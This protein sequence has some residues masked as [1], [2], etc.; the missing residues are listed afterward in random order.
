MKQ[1]SLTIDLKFR[2]RTRLLR[3]IL[4]VSLLCIIARMLYFEGFQ[5]KAYL[6]DAE[7]T[8]TFTEQLPAIRGTIYDRNGNKLAYTSIAYIVRA[9]LTMM[10]DARKHPGNMPYAGDP[11]AYAEKLSPLLNVPVDELY[12]KL[13]TP[14]QVGVDLSQTPVNDTVKAKIDALNLPGIFYGQAQTRVY[15]N[16]TLAAHVLG[17]VDTSGNG[18]Y[19]IEQE[20]DKQLSGTPGTDTYLKDAHGNPLPFTKQQLVAAKNGNDVYLTL[21]ETIQTYVEQ[22]LDEVVKQYNPDNASVIVADPKSG[23]ILAMGNRPTYDPNHYGDESAQTALNN[24]RAVNASFEPGSTFKLVPLTGALQENKINLDDTFKSGYI[25]VSGQRINDWWTPGW[26]QITFR[27]AVNVSSNVGFVIIGQKLGQDLMDKYMHEFGYGQPTGI[28]LPGEADSLLFPL[29]N[30][31][32]LQLATESFGQGLAVTPIQQVSAVTA[33]ANGGNVMKPF[34]MQKI[35]NPDTHQVVTTNQPVVRSKLTVDP[36]VLQT[37]RS[38]M[39]DDITNDESPTKPGYLPGYHIAGKTGTA[40]YPDP[41]TGLYYEKRYITSF[42]GFAPAQN[43]Q[44]EIYVT[45]QNPRNAGD[46]QFG[47]VVATPAAREIFSKALPYI[48]IQPDNSDSS[49]TTGSQPPSTDQ[50]KYV[51]APNLVGATTADAKSQVQKAGASLQLIGST[52]SITAQFPSPS[53][54]VQSS[55]SIICIAGNGQEADG[56]IIMPDLTGLSLKD[57]ANLLN[58]LGIIFQP[59]GEGFVAGQS[60]L[61]GTK[62]QPGSSVQVTFK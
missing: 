41:T 45:V 19:G 3:L 39:E 59:A 43:P 12:K 10:K 52:G 62:I 37:V 44:L 56:S 27:K 32:K 57:T 18:Q 55:Q 31:T 2:N 40:Q 8:W 53:V 7:K 50:T 21:D 20:Y 24:N 4:L 15:P 16:N 28:D 35:V 9:D 38:I 1:P 26:G 49:Q 34:L 11:Q 47:N 14:N 36:T 54:S 17:Y 58:K 13:T 60:I 48:G 22:A 51:Q 30:I 6:A 33:I 25:M 29:N 42:I 5:A 23:Q 46:N 61:K